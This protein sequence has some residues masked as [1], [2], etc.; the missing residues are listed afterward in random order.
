MGSSIPPVHGH[1]Q[2]K[3][4][5]SPGV[6]QEW[7]VPVITFLVT[8]VIVNLVVLSHQKHAS[9]AVVP[10]LINRAFFR[11]NL[12]ELSIAHVLMHL[13]IQGSPGVQQK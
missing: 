6:Q 2:K 4:I 3:R 5:I 11:L 13:H 8:G 12:T 10:L 9:H 7:I 1:H